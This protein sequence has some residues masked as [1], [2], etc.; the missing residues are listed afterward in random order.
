MHSVASNL[1]LVFGPY[2]SFLQGIS[3]L[4]TLVLMVE[5]FRWFP[6]STFI[7]P[8]VSPILSL[9]DLLSVGKGFLIKKVLNEMKF[10]IYLLCLKFWDPVLFL[11]RLLQDVSIYLLMERLEYFLTRIIFLS[12]G[13]PFLIPTEKRF[14]CSIK[15]SLVCFWDLIVSAI[16]SLNFFPNRFVMFLQK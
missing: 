11:Y 1:S 16:W 12:M 7:L 9:L 8:P 3:C 15:I 5:L 2:S 14:L 6:S 13:E 4:Q 10:C